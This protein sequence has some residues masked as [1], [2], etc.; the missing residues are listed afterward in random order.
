MFSPKTSQCRNLKKEICNVKKEGKQEKKRLILLLVE[1]EILVIAF[2]IMRTKGSK[3][4]RWSRK[5]QNYE[6]YFFNI[7]ILQFRQHSTYLL[8]SKSKVAN[9]VHIYSRGIDCKWKK[10]RDNKN[11]KSYR[12]RRTDKY[13]INGERNL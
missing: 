11:L 1:H 13:K 9:L 12:G 6:Y 3:S 10:G 2:I 5:S 8:Q 4:I 7:N